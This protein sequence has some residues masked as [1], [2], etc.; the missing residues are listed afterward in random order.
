MNSDGVLSPQE[1]ARIPA[2]RIVPKAGGTLAEA[3]DAMDVDHNGRLSS[4]ELFDG[5]KLV[6]DINCLGE[7]P[8]DGAP[9]ER[10][11]TVHSEFG[12]PIFIA[13][14]S[15]DPSQGDPNCKHA[16]SNRLGALKVP[17]GGNVPMST[18]KVP[19]RG[20]LF[21]P[22]STSDEMDGFKL[23]AKW[24]CD[25]DG[26]N[27]KFHQEHAPC[28]PGGCAIPGTAFEATFNVQG[29]GRKTDNVDLSYVDTVSLNALFETS[30]AGEATCTKSFECDIDADCAAQT[31][32]RCLDLTGTGAQKYCVGPIHSRFSGKFDDCPLD[33][34]LKGDDHT[35]EHVDLRVCKGADGGQVRCGEN[36]PVTNCLSPKTWLTDASVPD[37]PHLAPDSGSDVADRYSCAGKYN[38][39]DTCRAASPGN[40]HA[41][42]DPSKPNEF[43]EWVHANSEGVY[44]W[45]YDDD[46]GLYACSWGAGGY[47]AAAPSYSLTLGP[48]GPP[49]G[50]RPCDHE[51]DEKHEAL[52]EKMDDLTTALTNLKDGA[53]PL[54]HAVD[55][56]EQELADAEDELQDKLE[57]AHAAQDELVQA[58]K[59]YDDFMPLWE[60]TYRRCAGDNTE[61]CRTDKADVDARKSSLAAQ[62]SDAKAAANSAE[63]DVE[64]ARAVVVEKEA[65]LKYAYDEQAAGIRELQR[66][67]NALAGPQQAAFGAYLE[68]AK[69]CPPDELGP[70]QLHEDLQAQLVLAGFASTP[71]ADSADGV[72][73]LSADW[74][75]DAAELNI[76]DSHWATPCHVQRRRAAARFNRTIDAAQSALTALQEAVPRLQRVVDEKN[77]AV[78][79]RRE[80]KNVALEARKAAAAT[81]ADK[82]EAQH[83]TQQ[84]FNSAL[85]NKLDVGT[86]CQPDPLTPE[87]QANIAGANA[88]YTQAAEANALAL[89]EVQDAKAALDEANQNVERAVAALATAVAELKA[90][91][92]D[93]QRRLQALQTDI[94]TAMAAQR[95]ASLDYR[96][97][98]RVCRHISTEAT[99]GQVDVG[100]HDVPVDVA[101]QQSTEASESHARQLMAL[102]S[103]YAAGVEQQ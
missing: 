59:Q 70:Q 76:T 90:A 12:I 40:N 72:Q 27:C 57:A 61:P 58:Q 14:L 81:L 49:V 42:A 4:F 55:Q 24:G 97:V 98:L 79:L 51:R 95:R 2:D 30:D 37:G 29:P 80:E 44:A 19:A 8:S 21:V 22:V 87:C 83:A 89:Q 7:P 102:L 54:Q 23:Y 67:V 46:A 103:S 101:V 53:P 45:Q 82:R 39:R 28:G 64:A 34:T 9:D 62:L 5:A 18:C 31:G 6:D 38:T 65:A 11:I 26:Q 50:P 43:V 52:T 66:A 84:E 86:S 15:C 73:P 93:Q 36:D 47:P 56:A 69:D 78:A 33:I 85:Q 71:A 91:F 96:K 1:V 20:S 48:A 3:F 17:P 77:D 25:E 88:R 94:N 75:V 100:W 41:F 35:F 99:V 10:G 74:H 13:M 63:A 68:A 16:F 92:A 60:S 32:S